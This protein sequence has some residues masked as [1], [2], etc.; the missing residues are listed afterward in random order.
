MS[1]L[2]VSLA[3]CPA[4]SLNK[5]S[6]AWLTL[7]L[8]GPVVRQKDLSKGF[9]WWEPQSPQASVLFTFF[10]L[11]IP[12]PTSSSKFQIH[13]C[14][15]HFHLIVVPLPPIQH[16]Q[17]LTPSSLSNL[18]SLP[19]SPAYFGQSYCCFLFPST[20]NIRIVCVIPLLWLL[21][22]QLSNPV[23]KVPEICSSPSVPS[24]EQ[25]FSEF[26]VHN[27]NCAMLDL[28]ISRFF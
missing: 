22:D 24:S 18:N 7:Q 15:K 14:W 3:L 25:P 13:W 17:G 10:R 8:K 12:R 26:L 11:L 9:S 4:S 23:N 2:S 27:L 1:V 19:F 21:S 16:I 6:E 20:R 5:L 28:I